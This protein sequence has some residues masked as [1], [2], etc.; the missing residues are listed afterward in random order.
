MSKAAT[1][2]EQASCLFIAPV[3][4]W[5]NVKEGEALVGRQDACPTLVALC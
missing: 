1:S 3:R 4:K 5:E 2:V